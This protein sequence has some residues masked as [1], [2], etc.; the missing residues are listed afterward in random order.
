MKS[1]LFFGLV[2]LC[3]AKTFAEC[4]IVFPPQPPD[5]RAEPLL[6]PLTTQFGPMIEGT[7]VN[8]L[9]HVFAVHY[10]NGTNKLGQIS[11]DMG[12]FYEDQNTTSH[13]NGIRFLNRNTA[14]T[15]DV[16]NHRVVKLDLELVANQ[17]VVTNAST[18]CQDASMLQPNDLVVARSGTIFLSGMNWTNNGTSEDGDIWSCLPNG[19]AQRL[20]LMGRTNGIELT[21]D[22]FKMYVS[23]S[24]NMNGIPY[25]QR[26]WLYDVNP[27]NGTIFNKRLFVDF[28][29]LDGSIGQDI[30]GMRTD[31]AGNLFVTRNGGGQ[32]VV[33]NPNAE[34]IGRIYLNFARP[35]NLELGGPQGRT[36]FVVGACEVEWP[37]INGCV[38][39]IQLL[40]AGR[41]WYM[42]Q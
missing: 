17:T 31:L 21:A 34:V 22:D 41:S 4:P 25:V 40:T 30:D 13:F 26:I 36:L 1:L 6:T 9:G 19:T 37:G 24:H 35:T 32:V 14:F 33:F 42:L 7:S 3:V 27:G 16:V 18:F 8:H 28:E 23:E 15:V 20:E 2:A 10:T 38:D 29:T 5:C 11:P 39:T 12:L